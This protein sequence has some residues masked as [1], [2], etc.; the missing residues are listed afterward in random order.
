MNIKEMRQATNMTQK[1]FAE[2]FGIP[3]RTIED[4]ETEK[5]QPPKYVEDLIEYKL[6]NEKL[7]D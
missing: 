4:W 5:R 2:Y 7:L 6:K 1:A 3:R